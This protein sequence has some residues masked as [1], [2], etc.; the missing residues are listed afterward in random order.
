MNQAWIEIRFVGGESKKVRLL[1]FDAVAVEQF[2]GKPFNAENISMTENF[3]MA[4][5]AAKRN[6]AAGSDFEAWLVN[7]ESVEPVV[8]EV[9]LDEP[10]S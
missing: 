2:T 8:E 3:Y 6:N 1:P 5:S 10:K 9:P 7:V 4:Y